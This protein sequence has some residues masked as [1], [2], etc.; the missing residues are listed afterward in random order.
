MALAP[1]HPVA[2]VLRAL[3]MGDLLTAVPA[4]RALRAGM[5]GHRIVLAA[6]AQ[7]A[8]LVE[9]TGAV[10]EV[11]PAAALAPL[12]WASPPPDVAV[13]LHGSGPQSSRLLQALRPRRL[14]AYANA[15]AGTPGPSWREDERE[16]ARWHR[17]VVEGLGLPADPG[18]AER[19]ELHVPAGPSPRPG[20]AVV[21]PGAGYGSRRWPAERFAAVVAGLRSR[22]LDVVVTGSGEERTLADGVARDGGLAADSVLAGDLDLSSLAALVA[23][24]AV[25]VSGDTGIAHLATA[26]GTPSVVLFGPALPAVWGPPP[27]RDQHAVLWRGSGRGDLFAA[28]PSPALLALRVPEVLAAADRVLEGAGCRRGIDAAQLRRH[29]RGDEADPGGQLA[30]QA[31]RLR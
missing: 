5:P 9:L 13:N 6:P 30:L 8:P 14:V 4:L 18:G 10:D 11:L 20:A 26:Y 31:G 25:V 12:D 27:G 2:L 21:H 16:A 23:A 17:L 28:T 24:A 22:G 1:T 19:L 3:G 15:A 29:C 7:L